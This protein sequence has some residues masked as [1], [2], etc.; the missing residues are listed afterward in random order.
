MSLM[1]IN[2]PEYDTVIQFA[3][4]H[5]VAKSTVYHWIHAGLVQYSVVPYLGRRLYLIRSNS[6]RPVKKTVHP[7]WL[8][9]ELSSTPVGQTTPD[10]CPPWMD[11]PSLEDAL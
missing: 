11:E 5:N 7:F 10:D 4:R 2:F 9:P 6:P 3:K 8:F 1:T